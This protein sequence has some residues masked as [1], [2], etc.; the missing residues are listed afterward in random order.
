MLFLSRTWKP[1]PLYIFN[2]TGGGCKPIVASQ[3]PGF[4]R[5]LGPQTAGARTRARA[6][7]AFSGLGKGSQV[8][9]GESLPQPAWRG[10]FNLYLLRAAGP[11][12]PVRPSPRQ[13]PKV[14]VRRRR[15][16]SPGGTA[17][18]A[19]K[20]L[21]HLACPPPPA[22]RGDPSLSPPK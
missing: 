12:P 19:W 22:L 18:P 7:G 10:S 17:K 5:A 20:R 13:I 2:Q 16:W 4:P 1:P 9:A 6:S 11:G 14:R 8:G 15:V 21:L 3:G